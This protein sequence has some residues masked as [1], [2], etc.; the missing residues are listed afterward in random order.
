MPFGL[1]NAL[2]AFI[3]LMNWVFHEYLDDFIIVIFND[4][5][6]N[7]DNEPIHEEHLWLAL[8]FNTP[9]WPRISLNHDDRIWS[10]INLT[11][12]VTLTSWK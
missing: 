11:Y 3:D 12:E 2:V 4:A 1:A 6:I 5:L 7:F 8:D 9:I 10:T